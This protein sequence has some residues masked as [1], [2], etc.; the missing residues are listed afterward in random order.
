MPE[1]TMP[2]TAGN[3]PRPAPGIGPATHCIR[4]QTSSPNPTIV[5]FFHIDPIQET[6]FDLLL[7]IRRESRRLIMLSWARRMPL[8][9]RLLPLWLL[10]HFSNTASIYP[11]VGRLIM[12]CVGT[13]PILG[14]PPFSH[15]RGQGS[16]LSRRRAI[17]K[18]TPWR[19]MF[20]TEVSR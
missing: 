5:R 1:P 10:F 4:W 19:R 9:L 2:L 15:S 12:P 20:V 3:S 14:R 11:F 7:S 8:S 6:F 13:L 18:A 17:T 16:T